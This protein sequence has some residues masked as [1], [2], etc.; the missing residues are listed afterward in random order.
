[1]KLKK[2]KYQYLIHRLTES[3]HILEFST[4][5]E[6]GLNEPDIHIKFLKD[7]LDSFN[8]FEVYFIINLKEIDL[9]FL[10][11]IHIFHT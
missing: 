6:M 1:M 4:S 5:N 8:P 10:N 11:R 7:I 9:L 2:L 3:V